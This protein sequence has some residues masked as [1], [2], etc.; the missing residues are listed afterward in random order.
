MATMTTVAALT[1]RF[2]K[3][4]LAV[5]GIVARVIGPVVP[6][7]WQDAFINALAEWTCKGLRFTG[8]RAPDYII[9]P[10]GSL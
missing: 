2:P 9:P 6:H 5:A 8:H 10:K 4:R 1:V 3:R 7:H